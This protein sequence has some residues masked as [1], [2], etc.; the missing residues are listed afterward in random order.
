MKNERDIFQILDGHE[1]AHSAQAWSKLERR[2]GPAKSNKAIVWRIAAALLLLL[3]GT[4]A[5]YTGFRKRDG[6]GDAT[7]AQVKTTAPAKTEQNARPVAATEAPRDVIRKDQPV[8]Q[9][10]SVE[11]AKPTTKYLPNSR[12]RTVEVEKILGG[13]AK[14]PKQSA[15]TQTVQVA[16][17]EKTQ[18]PVVQKEVKEIAVSQPVQ[19][20]QGIAPKTETAR[21]TVQPIPENVQVAMVE[22]TANAANTEPSAFTMEVRPTRIAMNAEEEELVPNR[23]LLARIVKSANDLAKGK[24]NL[25][26]RGTA[27]L[28]NLLGRKQDAEPASEKENN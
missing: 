21:P 6:A 27:A 7:V 23:P 12:P 3:V 14:A 11:P 22:P 17:L 4:G 10:A 8:E 13:S 16:V 26:S 18:S 28:N 20:A 5:Y 2:L 24:V 15:S 25:K 1:E 19:V 9:I